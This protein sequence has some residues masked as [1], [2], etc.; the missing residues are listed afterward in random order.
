MRKSIVMLVVGLLLVTT[1][2]GGPLSR[3]QVSATAN[4][5][6]HANYERFNS[7]QLG[8]LIRQELVTQGI[9]EKLV[10]FAQVFSFHPLND[11]RDVTVYGNGKDREKAVVLI[12]GN[13]NREKLEALVR[14]NPQHKEVA[15]GD[16]TIHGWLHEE[17][18]HNEVVNS[19][20]M[21]GCF[22]QDKIV[23]MSAG[24]DS[25][26]QAIDVLKGAA[27]SATEGQFTTMP[28]GA[29]G[30]FFQAAANGVGDMA[31]QEEQAAVLRQADR[32]SLVI[33]ETEGKFYIDLGLVAKSEEAAQSVNK[34]LEG[35]VAYTAL[36]GQEKPRLAEMAQKTKLSCAQNIVSVHF[37]TT[38]E[39]IF[40]FLKEQWE[41]S[42]Q[43]GAQTQTH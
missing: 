27:Q 38:S 28:A 39:S 40:Q 2:F 37:E 42:Q 24:V 5:V 21:Y 41:K 9:E 8:K 14:M 43:T 30:V 35:I 18:K 20:M 16:I 10:N 3:N 29:Q 25:V 13:F 6:V 36:A 22:Y 33:G 19:F 32:L 23:V 34:V 17:R 4:W 11:V 26:K 7:S 15:H 12:D 31:G 1:A